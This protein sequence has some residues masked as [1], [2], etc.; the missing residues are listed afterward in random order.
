MREESGA[1]ARS[2]HVG[3]GWSGW[4]A[5]EEEMPRRVPIMGFVST[6]RCDESTSMAPTGAPVSRNMSRCSDPTP[7]SAA[8]L[9]RRPPPDFF[10]V[11]TGLHLLATSLMASERTVLRGAFFAMS[12]RL[13]RLSSLLFLFSLRDLSPSRC[14][15][16][17]RFCH[18][19][20]IASPYMHLDARRCSSV[21]PCAAGLPL[22]GERGGAELWLPERLLVLWPVL[23]RAEMQGGPEG[24]PC[25]SSSPA[26]G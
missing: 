20:G 22:P 15:A 26:A 21:G 8:A 4:G 2:A 7:P 9:G 19:L 24:A 23:G 14:L 5:S 11:L 10:L 6:T 1:R 25:P 18:F 12:R 13:R 3:S 17:S 16:L